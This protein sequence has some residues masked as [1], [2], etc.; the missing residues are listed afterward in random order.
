LT[1]I[2]NTKVNDAYSMLLGRP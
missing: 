2:C 1:V